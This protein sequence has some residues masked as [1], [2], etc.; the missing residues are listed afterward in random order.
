[1]HTKSNY[2]KSKKFFFQMP[3][4]FLLTISLLTNLT[5]GS[6][7]TAQAK[8]VV[9]STKRKVMKLKKAKVT[10][11]SIRIKWKK[12]KKV[13]GYEIY[14]SNSRKGKFKKIAITKK[15]TFNNK[16]LQA[17]KNYFYKVRAYKKGNGSKKY[18][19]FSSILRVK[20][21]AASNQ[22]ST[23][24]SPYPVTEPT[25]PTPSVVN[26]PT[27]QATVTSSPVATSTV[28]EPT[29]DNTNTPATGLPATNIPA[30]ITP[31][32]QAPATNIPA[33][34]PTPEASVTNPPVENTPQAHTQNLDY[35]EITDK[36][37]NPD[38]GF[39]RP[40][41]VSVNEEGVSYNENIITEETQLYHLRTDISAFSAANNGTTDLELTEA[42][43]TGIDELL[44]TLY[45]K[46][47]SAIIRFVYDP[48]LNGSSNKEP[49]VDMIVTHITQLAPILNKHTDTLTAIE[50]GLIGPWGEMHTSTIANAETINTLIEA[51]LTTTVDIPILVRTP[52]M[53]YN[54]LGITID[55]LSS[56]T[57]ATTSKAYRLGLFNDGY[58]GSSS[59]LGTYTSRETEVNWLSKQTSHLP[60]GGEVVVPDSTFHNIEN[61]LPEMYLLNLSY[62]NIE[63]NYEV[64][65]KWEASTYTEAAGTDSIYYGNTAFEY[66]Q[67]HMGYRFVLK[68]SVFTYPEDCSSLNIAL[69]IENVGFGNLNRSKQTTLLL[70]DENEEITSIHGDAYS[71]G[72]DISIE[73]PKAT[74]EQLASG[75]YT[76]YLKLDNG[77][78]KYAIQ[79]ANNL[80]NETLQANC[81]GTITKP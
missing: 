16:K 9:F 51:F 7:I 76:L 1:M 79:F 4:L 22:E 47:K 50:V 37:N 74:L 75:T 41:F 60:Y 58:L 2:P 19:R 33:T 55:D 56:Y 48:G 67:N 40:I 62:L 54:Y 32:T 70:V 44:S 3:I 52:K 30:T 64:I 36:I 38:Q 65:D 28:T 81:I 73:V 11:N 14:R 59:D 71:G 15:N 12:M 5:S 13:S 23:I 21:K 63:W 18:S 78:D 80:W 77:N 68:D 66:I 42:A 43:L 26:S 31:T 24:N 39:Y 69:S 49:A 35:S 8:P 17:S 46:N 53:I 29:T 34:T 20:T 72:T 10:S 27:P 57:I 6:I 45:N 61:C 25:Q